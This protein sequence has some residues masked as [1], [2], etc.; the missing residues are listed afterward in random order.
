MRLNSDCIRDI[1][2]F[3]EEESDFNHCADYMKDN[4]N[5]RL[6]KYQHEEIIYHIKQC[7]LSNLILNVHY[8]DGA[9]HIAIGDLSPTGHKF[10]AD[11]REDNI[12]SKVKSIAKKIGSTSLSA[13]TEIAS[14]VIAE[15]IK[16]QFS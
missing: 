8:Y 2:F 16:D 1:L 14:N 4:S 12:W 7:E 15:L 9:I 13:L 11:V 3:V 10:I 6:K 5:K